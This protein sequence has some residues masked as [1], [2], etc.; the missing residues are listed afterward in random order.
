[1][2]KKN[3]PYLVGLSSM[4]G[5]FHDAWRG[6][7][8]K[9]A[10]DVKDLS[11]LH[12]T[13]GVLDLSEDTIRYTSRIRWS[14]LYLFAAAILATRARWFPVMRTA[15]VPVSEQEEKQSTSGSLLILKI[16]DTN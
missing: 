12:K 8:C 7:G 5:N 15:Q 2:D 16:V 3:P 13:P 14:N 4:L 9:K 11:L 6:D 10:R 1:M